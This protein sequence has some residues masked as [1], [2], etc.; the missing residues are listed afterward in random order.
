MKRIDITKAMAAKSDQ[1]NADDLLS[2][3]RVIRIRDVQVKTGE[4]PVSIFF[5]GDDDKPWK[6]SKT[7]LRCLAAVWGDDG[8]KWIGL[9]CT[10]YND[11]TVKWA[12]VEVGGIRVSHMEGLSQPRRLMLTY[13]RGKKREHTIQPL[14]VESPVAKWKTRLFAVANGESSVTVKQ[15]WAKVPA[16]VKKELG[17]GI[18]DQLV[19]L[20]QAA[21]EHAQS[22][23]AQL[24]ELNNIL[25]AE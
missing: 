12:G 23:D 9:H 17:E 1:L 25:A 3:P 5:D 15:A 6:P 11:E 22:D 10:I 20:E 19:A 2:G 13:T 18:Y 8:Q 24:D 21:Q 16:D 14:E 4:Q 7:A